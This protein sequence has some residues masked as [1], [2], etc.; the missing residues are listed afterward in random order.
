MKSFK[1]AGVGVCV[2]ASVFMSYGNPQIKT[3]RLTWLEWD[4]R[5]V[6]THKYTYR[7]YT[8]LNML[9]II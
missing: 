2:S 6:Y 4:L 5:F 1:G 8:Y 9:E 3:I 7:K